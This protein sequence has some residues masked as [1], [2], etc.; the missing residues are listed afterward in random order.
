MHLP[1]AVLA[2][3]LHGVPVRC[4]ASD[5]RGCITSACSCAGS[6]VRLGQPLSDLVVDVFDG[7]QLHNVHD[8]V[9]RRRTSS[10]PICTLGRVKR[11]PRRRLTATPQRPA[12]DD[13]DGAFGASGTAS[14]ACPMFIAGRRLPWGTSFRR[15]GVASCFSGRSRSGWSR[16]ADQ[17]LYLS[18]IIMTE[19]YNAGRSCCPA[20]RSRRSGNQQPPMNFRHPTRGLV[21]L[22]ERKWAPVPGRPRASMGSLRRRSRS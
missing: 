2:V 15:R 16:A 10:G 19:R 22:V 6:V 4:S 20:A 17:P 7:S 18:A 5:L 9:T 13:L 14:V 1:A 21:W 3:D 11:C 12:W 8:A